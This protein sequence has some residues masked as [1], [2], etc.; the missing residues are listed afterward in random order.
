MGN[1][2]AVVQFLELVFPEACVL[3]PSM[4]PIPGPSPTLHKHMAYILL[5]IRGTHFN[6]K[7]G[8]V[9]GK[10]KRAKGSE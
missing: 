5:R 10:H 9:T 6:K 1:K 8:G 7:I 4:N 3:H 2:C